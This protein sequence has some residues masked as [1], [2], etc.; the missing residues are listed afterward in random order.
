MSD[1][2]EVAAMINLVRNARFG[3]MVR[4]LEQLIDR[5]LWRDYTTPAGT[6]FQFRRCEFD[7]FLAAQE[8]DPTTVRWAYLKADDVDKLPEK[9]FRLADIT[10]RGKAPTNGD[11]RPWGE[12]AEV[13]GTDPAGAGTRIRGWG[14][15]STSVVTP[16]TA[17]V[18]ADPVQR[19]AIVTGQ[20]TTK[21][22]PNAKSWRVWWSDER[23]TAQAIVDKLAEDPELADQAFKIM[24]AQ[25]DKNRRSDPESDPKH[26]NADS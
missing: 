12:V 15:S 17:R 2:T 8:I 21:A 22:R 13:Y 14:Q 3:E 24:R 7:Y 10:G 20:A 25:Y 19:E 18:A 23:T 11:R 26:R 4:H 9:Q 6:R 16:M 1:Y 5:D